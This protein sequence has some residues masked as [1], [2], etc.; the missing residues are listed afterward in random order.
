MGVGMT[1]QSNGW[2]FDLVTLDA[3]RPQGN[4][5]FSL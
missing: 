4:Q 2:R 5:T 3:G 1:I